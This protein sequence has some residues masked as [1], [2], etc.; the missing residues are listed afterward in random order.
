MSDAVSLDL[1]LELLVCVDAK[2]GRGEVDRWRGSKRNS[3][4][5][6]PIQVVARIAAGTASSF[7]SE[8]N[9]G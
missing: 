3:F 1:G 6:I 2:L 4:R 8:T 7:C 5:A 9:R